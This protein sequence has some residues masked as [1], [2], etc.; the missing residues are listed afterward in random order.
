MTTTTIGGQARALAGLRRDAWL[1]AGVALATT[2]V[3][4]LPAGS[5]LAAHA[6]QLSLFAHMAG[7][8]GTTS[9]IADA[10]GMHER[11]AHVRPRTR[12]AATTP[13]G[14]PIRGQLK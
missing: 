14:S 8:S 12:G 5:D 6:Y 1:A 4:L 10:T 9:G 7:R 2:L 13:R 11:Q 3:L